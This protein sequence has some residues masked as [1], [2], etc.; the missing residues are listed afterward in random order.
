MTRTVDSHELRGA[1]PGAGDTVPVRFDP[2]KPEQVDV[3]LPQWRSRLR[4]ES[5]SIESEYLH[6]GEAEWDERKQ[7]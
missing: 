6:R 4:A 2:A 1:Y 3:D 7:D 5:E